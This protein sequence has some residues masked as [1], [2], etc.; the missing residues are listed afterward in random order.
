MMPYEIAIV[1]AMQGFGYF[2]LVLFAFF[3]LW[4]FLPRAKKSNTERR[5]NG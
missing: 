1:L 3:A 2:L 4:A 5:R